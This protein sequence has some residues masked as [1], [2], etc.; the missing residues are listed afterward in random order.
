MAKLTKMQ[1]T[2]IVFL[3]LILIALII[4]IIVQ[5]SIKDKIDPDT[6]LP[7][8]YDWGAFWKWTGIIVG[9]VLV[10][11]LIT[12]LIVYFVGRNS[13]NNLAELP[14][15]PVS[16]SR[17][18][19]IWKTMWI[20]NTGIAHVNRFWENK[21]YW[22]DKDIPPV[23]PDREDAVEIFDTVSHVD[24]TGQTGDAFL[25]FEVFSRAG[26]RF[27]WHTVS[28]RT[29]AGEK[30]IRENWNARVTHHKGLSIYQLQNKKYPLTSAKDSQDRMMNKKLE[31]MQ[32]GYSAEE[33]RYFDQYNNV[34][35]KQT[36]IKKEVPAIATSN[37]VQASSSTSDDDEEYEDTVE[38]D[39]EEYRRKN[40]NE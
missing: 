33:L 14:K 20:K 2:G 9:S 35:P 4:Y 18:L 22:I 6:G 12:V 29:D 25:L 38:S 17:A 31:L 32:E 1:W 16:S 15:I 5:L 26:K 37:E 27:G 39:V 11:T 30:W 21:K 28:L 7:M 19:D 40:K 8:K 10:L 24:P 13:S 36:V 23:T 3:A 34:A